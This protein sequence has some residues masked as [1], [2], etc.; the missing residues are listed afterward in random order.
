M[1]YAGVILTLASLTNIEAAKFS[2]ILKKSANF[3]VNTA[4]ADPYGWEVQSNPISKHSCYASEENK[5]PKLT[6]V[7]DRE[8]VGFK[9]S[10]SKCRGGF[11][12][13][14]FS[15][16]PEDCIDCLDASRCQMMCLSKG[17]D[18]AALVLDAKTRIP[19]ECRCGATK[20]NGPVWNMLRAASPDGQ[21]NFGPVHGLLPPT[22]NSAVSA[23]DPRCAMFVY[24][25]ADE[26]EEN[27]GVPSQFVETGTADDFYIRSIVSGM[28]DPGDVEDSTV[29]EMEK[30]H[31][32]LRERLELWLKDNPTGRVPRDEIF[33]E[34]IPEIDKTHLSDSPSSC[35][36]I[37]EPFTCFDSAIDSVLAANGWAKQGSDGGYTPEYMT[38]MMTISFENW[39]AMFAA[40]SD[41]IALNSGSYKKSGFCSAPANAQNCPI[42]CGKCKLYDRPPTRASM[43]E[44]WMSTN[45]DSK[46][47]IVSIPYVF[48][49]ANQFVTP[50]LM[51]MVRNASTIWGAVTCVNFQETAQIPSNQR[52]ILIT[53]DVDGTGKPSGCL[54]DPV[55]LAPDAAHPT[56]INVGGCLENKKPLGSLIH[57]FGHVLGLIHTQMRPDRDQYIQMNPAMV[58]PGFEANFFLSP[59]GFDG[60]NSQYSPYDLGSIMHYTRTQ[61]ANSA[62]YQAGSAD[63]SG[64]FKMLQP[65][66][67]GVVL[68]QR[69]QLSTLDIAEVNTLYQCSNVLVSTRGGSPSA[70]PSAAPAAAA[71]T[72]TAAPVASNNSSS[73]KPWD[74]WEADVEAIADAIDAILKSNN[75]N[76]SD[77]QLEILNNLTSQEKFIFNQ[78]DQTITFGKVQPGWRAAV[79][80]VA[81]TVLLLVVE[82]R[83]GINLY[84]QGKNPDQEGILDFDAINKLFIIVDKTKTLYGKID[85][86]LQTL[87][88]YIPTSDSEELDAFKDFELM[89]VESVPKALVVF[90]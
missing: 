9:K 41:Q 29:E 77:Q 18:A 5:I 84:K 63:W 33:V 86:Y 2:A 87:P 76:L 67:A 1:L 21:I 28:A 19:R 23:D 78:A 57:E 27:G 12:F 69:D 80:R 90:G 50:A 49:K 75:I 55:G 36:G 6:T 40:G 52:Y 48:D 70:S 85:A 14:R 88:G 68:G 34:Q 51:D 25:Y 16:G 22:I 15:A 66:A 17:M 7:F 38:A 26:R 10:D 45:K 30:V 65:L 44:T 71:A 54:A 20:K 82:A 83:R 46:T 64:T 32:A 31:L 79:V 81:K 4:T 60:S 37:D 72:T 56:R 73:G 62:K 3:R 58:K 42:T 89:E 74:G 43:Y 53:A 39:Q 59:Y 8:C 47:G 13:Y 61:A 24:L 35:K 11:P